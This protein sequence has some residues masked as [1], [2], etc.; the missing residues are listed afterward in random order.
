MR[1]DL[2]S[3]TLSEILR[4]HETPPDAVLI[5]HS[6]IK[7][8]GQQGFRAERMIEALLGYLASGTLLMP[9]M[10]WRTVT[11]ANP[12][13]DELNTPSHTGVLTEIFRTRH[14][15][16]R[17]LHPTHSVAGYGPAAAALLAK[18]HLG[19]TSVHE[20]SPYALA[21]D[22]PTFILLLGVGLE[23]CTAIHLAEETLAPDIYVQPPENTEQY[24]LRDRH[25][26]IFPYSLRRHRRLNR[27][28]EKFRV[29]LAARGQLLAGNIGG[30]PWSLMRQQDLLREVFAAL[31][32][33]PTATLSET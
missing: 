6:A 9:T 17:S 32:A 27:D 31:A 7:R 13:F 10:T 23:S 14:A 8:L 16:A 24:E 26:K 4:R 25:G 19:T 29:P 21:R 30:V 22:H 12:V 20:N 1:D 18:H 3:A 15:T 5:V 28:F 33:R 2:E 11:P